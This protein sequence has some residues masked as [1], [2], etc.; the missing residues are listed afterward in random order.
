MGA[1]QSNSQPLLKDSCRLI[2]VVKLKDPYCMASFGRTTWPRRARASHRPHAGGSRPG[3]GCV[4]SA[5]GVTPRQQGSFCSIARQNRRNLFC[6]AGGGGSEAFRRRQFGSDRSGSRGDHGRQ[7]AHAHER[8]HALHVAGEHVDRHL[9]RHVRL[10]IG[11]CVAL[12]QHTRIVR[13]PHDLQ[14]GQMADD[15][16]RRPMDSRQ[17]AEAAFHEASGTPGEATIP[18][19]CQS[20]GLSSHRSGCSEILKN[21]VLAGRIGSTKH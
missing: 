18:P 19:E 20:A 13:L 8:H 3:P 7:C 12:I 11:K 2:L 5:G 17:A 21:P 14:G 6:D 4:K 15:R 9:G 1:G 16:M 10:H